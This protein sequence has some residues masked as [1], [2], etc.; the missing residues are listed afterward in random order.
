[1]TASEILAYA[2][3]QKAVVQANIDWRKNAFKGNERNLTRSG[4]LTVTASR[5]LAEL[6]LHEYGQLSALND[7]ILGIEGN[8]FKDIGV[9]PA[10]AQKS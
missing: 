10:A 7:I 9:Q 6:T 5:R 3:A 2:K 4:T 1:M 8:S